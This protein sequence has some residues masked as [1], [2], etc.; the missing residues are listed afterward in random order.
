MK[1]LR[2]IIYVLSALLFVACARERLEMPAGNGLSIH[3]CCD[4]ASDIKVGTKST[5]SLQNEN[6]VYNMY[7]MIFDSNTK[8][9]VLSKYFDSSNKT[10]DESVP[11]RWWPENS[12][13]TVGTINI[14][15]NSIPNC[16]IY[17]VANIDADMVNISPEL[18][19]QVASLDDLESL[20]ATLNQA[21]IFRNGYFPM[22]GRVE[23][24]SNS[25]VAARVNPGQIL[26]SGFV[27][28]LRRLDAKIMFRVR[29]ASPDEDS[30]GNILTDPDEIEEKGCKIAAF[31]PG[32]WQVIN[33]PRK[34]YAFEKGEFNEKSRASSIEDA[35]QDASDFFDSAVSNFE[36]DIRQDKIHYYCGSTKNEILIHPFSFYMLENRRKPILSGCNSYDKREEQLKGPEEIDDAGRSTVKNGEFKYADP[37]SAY[38]VFSGRIEKATPIYKSLEG[39]TLNGEATYVVHLGDFSTQFATSSMDN[40]DVFRNHTYI[41]NITIFDVNDIRVEVE[42]NNNGPSLTSD[43][44]DENEPGAS[45]EVTISLEEIFE[46]DAHY[47][48]HVMT[49]HAKNIDENGITWYVKTPFNPDGARPLVVQRDGKDY[50]V[51]EGIDYEW[52][53]FR[54]N[55]MD[56]DSK[57]Y[58]E[59]KRQRFK[60]HDAD[61]PIEERTMN[62]SE[63]V[64]FLKEQK[65]RYTKNLSNKFDQEVDAKGNPNPKISVT[66]FVDEYY[67]DKNPLTKTYNK[68]LWREFVNQPMRVMYI[69]SGYEQS[70]DK[71]SAVIGSSL[72]I[73]QKSIQTIYNVSNPG[74]NS[75]WGCEHTDDPLEGD[76]NETGSTYAN[77]NWPSQNRQNTSKT[78]GRANTIKEWS[79]WSGGKMTS[80]VGQDWEDYLNL[81]ADNETPLMNKDYQYLRYS[82]MSRNRDLNGN[83]KID[84][85]EIRWYMAATNQ[86]VGLFL[87]EYGIEGSAKLYQRNVVQRA[88]SV[89]TDW[90]QHVVASTLFEG[91][92]NSNNCN[93]NVWAEETITGSYVGKSYDFSRINR[94]STRC[95]RNLGYD[96]ATNADITFSE[97]E[98]EPDNFIVTKR[99][100]DGEEYDGPYDEHVY[101][102]FDCTRINEASL[103]YY[104]KM[105]LVSHDEHDIAACLPHK[106]EAAPKSIAPTFTAIRLDIMNE[107]LD[108]S[109]EE[110]PYCPKGYRLCNIRELEVL[111]D[112]IPSPGDND[113]RPAINFA[114]THWSFGRVGDFYDTK[115]GSGRSAYTNV[116]GWG[117]SKKEVKILMAGHNDDADKKATEIRCVRDIE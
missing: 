76:N 109:I 96:P 77:S 48:S 80:I 111:W 28:R 92:T 72:S 27:L 67:Y 50:D 95:V 56:P 2:T 112:F 60:P 15:T 30:E 3:F 79:T 19:Q 45:G 113:F 31:T 84:Q 10:K 102:Q 36:M 54:L 83:G 18:L 33:M 68:D 32:K 37:Y 91:Q 106:F 94:F 46:C 116:W 7:V 25:S 85:N 6:I 105:E 66:A 107:N 104:T 74:L 47:G 23:S 21:T 59:R 52:V 117:T 110:N 13:N 16:V 87:G 1:T 58:Y 38:V 63:L 62:V 98:T 93:R 101:Y 9:K 103:R 55:E 20:V 53:W 70:A 22:T 51:T 34:A 14:M 11:D 115:K 97:P 44:L 65:T 88:S 42:V 71:E 90:C 81:E 108:L 39:V 89:N 4:A 41:Y 5:L 75:A 73:H 64:A 17:A 57:V 78:N 26:G 24:I 61:D 8:K 86:L 69:L 114:R 35:S 12:D 29:V 100:K 40:F 82:C 99:M 43:N 49:F